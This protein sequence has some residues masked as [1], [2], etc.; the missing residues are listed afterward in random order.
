LHVTDTVVILNPFAGN[1]ET[2]RDW[3][4]RVE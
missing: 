1:L 3:Q 4:E 2:V